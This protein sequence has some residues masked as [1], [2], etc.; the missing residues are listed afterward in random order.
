MQLLQWIDS[1]QEIAIERLLA[2]SA[3]SSGSFNLAGLALMNQALQELFAPLAEMTESIPLATRQVLNDAGEVEEVEHGKLLKFSTRPEAPVQVLLGGHMDTVFPADTSFLKPDYL[4][5]NT[6]NG[7]GVA[8]MKGGLLCIWLA[9]QAWEKR[10]DKDRLGWQVLINPDEETGSIASAPEL[11]KAAETA[12][13]GMVYEPALADGTLAGQ[14]KGSGNFSLLVRGR[15]AH[16]GREFDKGRN[17]IAALAQLMT[18]LHTLNRKREGLTLN[19][20]RI[21]GGG[22]LN[23][24]PDKAVC[25]F[26]VRAETADDFNWFQAKLHSMLQGGDLEEG[27]NCELHGGITRQPKLM[28]EAQQRLFEWL[29]QCGEQLHLKVQQHPTGGCCDGNNLAAAGLPNIDTLGVRGGQIHTHDEFMLVDSL[30]ER[31]RLSYLFLDFLAAHPDE[32]RH[33]RERPA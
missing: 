2:L 27:I 16:A 4:D 18:Q 20:G 29:G 30:T 3:I 7:P 22:V 26:N 19:L 9:L 6:L 11:A 23:Q 24:V 1:Q 10:K 12:H 28:N 8:D 21:S 31:A 14:R 32:V 25:H 13:V 15:S 5:D 33:L 17:A